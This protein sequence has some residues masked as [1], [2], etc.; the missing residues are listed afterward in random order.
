[1]Y[2]A[3]YLITLIAALYASWLYGKEI[4]PKVRRWKMPWLSIAFTTIVIIFGVIQV[5]WPQYMQSLWRDPD[6][7]LSGEWWRLVTALVAQNAGD[8]GT[9]FSALGLLLIG[10]FAEQYWKRLGWAAIFF[11]GA[12]L[13]NIAA[14]YLLPVGGGTEVGV[15][16][17]AGAMLFVCLQQKKFSLVRRTALIGG[18]SALC[19]LAMG[20]IHG[21]AFIAGMGLAAVLKKKFFV[22]P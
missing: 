10:S 14:V 4:S 11:G 9:I 3:F 6:A 13:S 18:V 8:N 2:F 17:L 5:V 21:I 19:I 22:N 12:V 16:S 15:F 1:M 7:I 20:D